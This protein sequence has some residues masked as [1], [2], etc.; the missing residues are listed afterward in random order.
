[1]ASVGLK[2]NSDTDLLASTFLHIILPFIDCLEIILIILRRYYKLD[3]GG[4]QG[5]YWAPGNFFLRFVW[6][7]KVSWKRSI[8]TQA[9]LR[10]EQ[11]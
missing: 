2:V 5:S 7:I 11:N 8:I 4:P 3:R 6:A 10:N 1:M 9:S